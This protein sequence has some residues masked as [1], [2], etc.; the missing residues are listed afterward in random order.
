MGAGIEAAGRGA[1]AGIRRACLAA[2]GAMRAVRYD[3]GR[4]PPKPES[5]RSIAKAVG[6]YRKSLLELRQDFRETVMVIEDKGMYFIERH[7]LHSKR[8]GCVDI[9][10]LASVAVS[11]TTIN[12]TRDQHLSPY[13]KRS[14]IWPSS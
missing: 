4:L 10:L 13:L 5:A 7:S 9:H 12:R 8:I 3:A 1:A 11:D 14:Q 2:S 6:R